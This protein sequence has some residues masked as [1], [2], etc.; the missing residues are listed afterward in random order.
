MGSMTAQPVEHGES[1]GLRDYVRELQRDPERILREL[2]EREREGFLR[3]YREAM[4]DAAADVVRW[5]ELQNL[6]RLWSL[7]VIAT[8]RSGYYEGLEAA[9]QPVRDGDG[10]MPLEEYL[11]SRG[12]GRSR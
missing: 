12:E 1:G 2:P 6:L 9:R 11:A 8:N 3:A 10:S 5:K 4:Q 7:R